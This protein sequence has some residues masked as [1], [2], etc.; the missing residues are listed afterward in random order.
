MIRVRA[1]QDFT[2][3]QATAFILSLKTI[4]QEKTEKH[5]E[6]ANAVKELRMFE[7]KVDLLLF[8]AFDLYVEC[9]EQIYRLKANEEKN[10]VF[11]AFKRAGLISEIADDGPDLNKSTD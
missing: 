1:I 3:S 4:V 5:L 11:K 10:K 6:K 9:R 8:L 2:P 7:K